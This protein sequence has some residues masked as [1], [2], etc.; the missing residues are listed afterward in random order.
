MSI[1]VG[2][3]ISSTAH[4]KPEESVRVWQALGISVMD[5]GSGV[6]LDRSV[7]GKRP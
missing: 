6:V 2:G 4:L 3:H 7:V 1:E 5:L